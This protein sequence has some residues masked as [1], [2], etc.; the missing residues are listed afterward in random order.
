M[1]ETRVKIRRTG[2]MMGRRT[3]LVMLWRLKGSSLQLA[4]VVRAQCEDHYCSNI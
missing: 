3:E 4:G 2:T 1:K